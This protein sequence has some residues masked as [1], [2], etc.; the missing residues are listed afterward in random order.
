MAV[1]QRTTMVPLELALIEQGEFVTRLQES[2]QQAQSVA[3]DYL[4]EHAERARGSKTKLVAEVTIKC[5]D[6][7]SF[8][9]TIQTQIKLQPPTAPP[10]TT[11][12]TAAETQDEQLRLWVKSTGSA[13]ED[14][15]QGVF[16]DAVG[17]PV[18]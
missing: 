3:T 14:P 17:K 12:A 1:Q 13:S 5:E 7:A 4:N 18:G 15:N 8:Y 16:Q 2:V 11:S 9:F 10:V 6:P